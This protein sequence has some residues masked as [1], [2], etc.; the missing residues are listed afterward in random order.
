MPKNIINS[1]FT[2]LTRT[3]A[4]CKCNCH[5]QFSVVYCL[6]VVTILLC[7]KIINTNFNCFCFIENRL[8]EKNVNYRYFYFLKFNTFF[9]VQVQYMIF[10]L[11]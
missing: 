11:K 4:Y 8:Y 2:L 7:F 10:V 6:S 3:P 5:I 1:S 9:I